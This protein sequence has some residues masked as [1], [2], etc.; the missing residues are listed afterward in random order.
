M[1][2]SI[3][4]DLWFAVKGVRSSPAI[5]MTAIVTLALGIGASTAT[6]S[7]VDGVLLQQ[8]PFEEPVGTEAR[9]STVTLFARLRGWSISVPLSTA[10][11]YAN[12]CTGIA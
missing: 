5:S 2:R 11:W 1:P 7:V 4:Q 6:F 12:S 10:T 9:Y 8:G 3:G